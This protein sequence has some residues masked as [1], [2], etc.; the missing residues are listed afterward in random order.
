MVPHPL[1]AERLFVLAPLC[2]LDPGAVHPV[3]HRTMRDL[4]AGEPL[5]PVSRLNWERNK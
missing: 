2:D 4:Y 5:K 1:L 3:L